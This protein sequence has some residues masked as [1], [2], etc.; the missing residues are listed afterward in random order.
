MGS[1]AGES[2]RDPRTET[3]N[4]TFE[5][6]AAAQHK[7][8]KPL[9]PTLD[10]ALE[11][12]ANGVSTIPVGKDK[13]PLI[14][15]WRKYMNDLPSVSDQQEWFKN[16]AGIALVAGQVQCIDIDEKYEPGL[17]KKFK[18]RAFEAGLESIWKSCLIQR[19]PSGGYHLVFMT[20]CEPFRNMKLAQKSADEGHE[21]LI[22]TRGMGGYF[23]IAPSEGYEVLQGDFEFLPCLTEDER[24]DLLD[25]ARSFNRRLKEDEDHVTSRN[26]KPGALTPGDEFDQR[27]DV[28]GLLV[29]HG[30]K[31]VGKEHWRR[32]GKD[33]GIS[34]SL[35]HVPGRFYVFSTSTEFEPEKPYKP[36]AVYAML[37]HCGD[38]SRATSELA[39][40]GYGTKKL[41]PKASL[42]KAIEVKS[43]EEEAAQ[44]DKLLGRLAKVEF[45]PGPEPE[46]ERC[47]FKLAGVEIAHIGNHVTLIAPIKSGKSAFI[48]AILAATTPKIVG[49]DLLGLEFTNPEGH[50]VIHVDT[51][52]SRND[53]HRLLTRSLRRS[54]VDCPPDYLLSFCMTGWEPQDIMAGIEFVCDKA[55]NAFGGI[56]SIVVDGLADLIRSPNDEE[57]SNAL[58]RW[59]R[60]LTIQ[61]QC[62]GFGVIHQNPGSDK[63]RGHLGSQ[64][65]RKSE[66][67]LVLEKKNEQMMIYSTRTRRAPILKENAPCFEW[68]DEAKTHVSCLN[69]FMQSKKGKAP[70]AE[71]RMD[72]AVSHLR[73]LLVENVWEIHEL[74][75]LIN[76]KF[77]IGQNARQKAISIAA[78]SVPGT[79]KVKPKAGRTAPWIIGPI[80][81]V[82]ERRVKME[83]EFEAQKQQKTKV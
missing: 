80:Q 27:G 10:T 34:A 66:T 2:W 32:P 7:S 37:E 22:E 20:T 5:P 8:Q 69:S 49:A 58:E 38:F 30:W 46:D 9:K 31:K 63:S 47:L 4:E 42:E 24:E 61:H 64:F 40:Q 12:R 70:T 54:G 44:A 82:A 74:H 83:Q 62:C 48:G 76:A 39:R 3:T 72:M 1:I 19:T 25:V 53:H 50:A 28:E 77:N 51:E 52:Q 65:E 75:N 56:H 45:C 78:E 11:L 33:K 73:T 26:I 57:D 36:Y 79:D 18:A 68:S 15:S 67:V 6:C 35:G 21:T 41:E 14:P 59:F 16:G 60:N 13:R 81:K 71:N 23:L 29:D 43:I 17:M 55:K